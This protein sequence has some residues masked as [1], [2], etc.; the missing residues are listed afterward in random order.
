MIGIDGGTFDVI[1]PMIARGRLP[2]IARLMEEGVWNT[3]SSTYPPITIPAWPAMVTGVNPGKMGVSFFLKNLHNYANNEIVTVHDIRAKSLWHYLNEAGKKTLIINIPYL[4]PPQSVDGAMVSYLNMRGAQDRIE[5]FPPEL[6][7]EL[8]EVL[9]LDYMMEKRKGFNYISEF[10]RFHG[11]LHKDFWLT[12]LIDF[13]RIAVDF[14]RQGT[15]YLMDKY[16]WDF[17]M[18]VFNSTDFLQHRLWG[19]VD[20][21]NPAHDKALAKKYSEG[22]YNCYEEIDRA[23][24]DIVARCSNGE[25]VLIVSDHG[26]AS[27]HKT[28]YINKW[29]ADK[30]L[31]SLKGQSPYYISFKRVPIYRILSKLYLSKFIWFLPERIKDFRIPCIYRKARNTDELIDWQRTKVYSN[32]YALNINLLGRE[33]HGIVPE[34][35][36]WSTV[37]HVKKELASLHDDETGKPIIDKVFEK[38]EIYTGPYVDQAND[39]HFFFNPPVYRVSTELFSDCVLERISKESK[40]TGTH[41]SA[42]NG[43]FIMRGPGVRKAASPSSPHIMDVTPT[44]LYL[45]GI[46]VPDELDGRVLSEI[47]DDTFLEG[48]PISFTEETPFLDE[49]GEEPRG[50][51]KEE[52]GKLKEMLE[53]L[54]YL[55]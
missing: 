40:L 25:N 49:M 4:F 42:L 11:D 44:I 17:L 18:V 39:I 23:I 21:E 6:V 38:T 12:K 13:H 7:N 36:Y 34:N 19:L 55:G 30:D 24:G 26:F 20:Q 32:S 27:L 5:T 33:P 46:P 48:N 45:S 29:L 37:D 52:Q 15:T 31:L 53:G 54:G 50:M 41:H 28:F 22:I 10:R 1:L 51:S 9:K 8:R 3:L 43:I 35:E 14:L 47:F 2:H 16:D